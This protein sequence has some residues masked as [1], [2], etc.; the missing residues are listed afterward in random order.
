MLGKLHQ[1]SSRLIKFI[2]ST[3]REREVVPGTVTDLID[4]CPIWAIAVP[5]GLDIGKTCSGIVS[6]A[7]TDSA[8]VI[9]KDADGFIS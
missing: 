5:L 4:N 6:E 9:R 2:L 3:E 8:C 7:L 1:K